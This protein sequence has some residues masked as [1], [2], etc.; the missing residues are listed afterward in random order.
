MQTIQIPSKPDQE[1]LCPVC[2]EEQ[3]QLTENKRTLVGKRCQV[4]RMIR[5]YGSAKRFEKLESEIEM[6]EQDKMQTVV[7][8]HVLLHNSARNYPP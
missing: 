4:I 3:A 6:L 7:H 8:L 5:E 2:N 1:L